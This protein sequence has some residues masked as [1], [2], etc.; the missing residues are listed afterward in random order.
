MLRTVDFFFALFA[1][2]PCSHS[3]NA[4]LRQKILPQVIKMSILIKTHVCVCM[5]W[6]KECFV[7]RC[8]NPLQ[9][10]ESLTS[11]PKQAQALSLD[12]LA[13]MLPPHP[14]LQTSSIYTHTQTQTATAGFHSFK[15]P[16]TGALGHC[17]AYEH[18]V[19]HACWTSTSQASVAPRSV[20]F[21]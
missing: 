10:S 8:S 15:L 17:N 4:L 7:S 3:D 9:G 11:L 16:H 18:R 1:T 20:R 13:R 2:F 5:W 19:S 12:D 14:P 6:P 21:N